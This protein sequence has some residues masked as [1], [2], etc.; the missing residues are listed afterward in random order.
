MIGSNCRFLQGPKTQRHSVQRLRQAVDSGQ[1]LSEALLN[2]RRDGR[3]FM[4][5]LMIAPL[6]DNKGNV[7]Y[8]IGAQVDASGLIE[9]GKGLDGFERYLANEKAKRKSGGQSSGNETIPI[10]G[11]MSTREAKKKALEKLGELSEMFDF[12]EDAVVV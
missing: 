11:R 9:G 5:I 1:E 7:K 8:H 6:H 12:E 3:P 4:N 2:Y 10:P